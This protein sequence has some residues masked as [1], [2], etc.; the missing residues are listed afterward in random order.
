[1]FEREKI[2]VWDL[3]TNAS[4]D[5]ETALCRT[6]HA[7]SYYTG[8]Y[9]NWEYT[10]SVE[11][12]R[13][14]LEFH[15]VFVT[16]NGREFDI[17]ILQ[18]V[19]DWDELKYKR[20]IDLMWVVKK[21]HTLMKYGGYQRFS[22]RALAKEFGLDEQKSDLD[23]NKLLTIKSTW[24]N[25]DEIFKYGEQDI[26]TTKDMFQY[27]CDYFSSFKDH[28]DNFDIESWKWLTTSP[29]S[30]AYKVICHYSGIKE[31][32]LDEEE[33][34]ELGDIHFEGGFV[35]LPTK[36]E[37]HDDIY[38]C[39][40]SSAYPHAFMMM[41]LF[42]P[43]CTCC[44]KEEKYH[45]G[46]IFDEV[47][48]HY[49]NK[50][51]HPITETVKM[52][53]N[54]R[55]QYKKEKNPKQ[56]SIKIIIN[57]I[58]GASSNP[59]FKN[60]FDLKGASDCTYFCRKSIK[61]A[62]EVFSKKGYDVLY[63]DSVG[64]ESKLILKNRSGEIGSYSF[65]KLWNSLSRGR[66]IE[67]IGSKEYIYFE[68]GEFLSESMN[69]KLEIEWK[70]VKYIMRHKNKK[71]CYK[72]KQNSTN[73]LLV[74]EDHSVI[75]VENHTHKLI[76]V[77][78]ENL[79][80]VVMN[81]GNKVK[82]TRGKIYES[83]ELFGYW[84]GNGSYAG[85]YYIGIACG[86]DHEE[87]TKKV[88]EHIVEFKG[89]SFKPNNKGDIKVCSK[90]VKDYMQ[91][92]GF[93][94]TSKTKRIPSFVFEMEDDYKMSFIRG[95]FSADG[96]VLSIGSIRYTTV[97]KLLAE[98]LKLLLHSVGVSSTIIKESNKNK[99]LGKESKT[100]SHH[101]RISS[102]CTEHFKNNIGFIFNRKQ[103]RI[104]TRN[105]IVS[106]SYCPVKVDKVDYD[107]YVY[108][109]EI[110][111]NHNFFANDILVHNTDSV[112]IK[113]PYKNKQE[114]TNTCKS[115]ISDIQSSVPFPTKTFELEI[116]DEISDMWFYQ[117]DKTGEFK[118]KHYIYR[119][120]EG[121]VTLKGIPLIKRDATKLSKKIYEDFIK[122]RIQNDRKLFVSKDQIEIWA[123]ELIKQDM[124][125]VARDFNVKH[126]SKY[127][128]ETSIHARVSK[129][130]GEG[131]H[132]L[133][134]NNKYGVGKNV[135]YCTYEEFKQQGL[136]ISDC[137]MD[138]FWTEMSN[139]I[140]ED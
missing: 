49:C 132:V 96:T 113:D 10:S 78:P 64:G 95:M 47:Q 23:Y 114:V 11:K 34:D 42:G 36:S 22:M 56:F 115:I 30:Y 139:F 123:A 137:D 108:D 76:E 31:E 87:F 27:L 68:D 40:F 45:G 44:T 18:R 20:N 3:E 130:Y 70:P 67:N 128:S 55:L 65:D 117:D 9:Y 86:L 82:P 90:K 140:K 136:T 116:D 62:R 119:T 97:N 99:Y 111:E 131:L 1:M 84:I 102:F 89:L 88:L 98:D 121:K 6:F 37:I 57:T 126:I 77:K 66:E 125:L 12:I 5:S 100:Y 124:S 29:G 92:I 83:A 51:L 38:A 106:Y 80:K 63:T 72:I 93:V 94:G 4:V 46:G 101:I 109:I 24:E 8:N 112:Y 59:I 61:H 35:A 103:D 133:I 26:K 71:Q 135:K 127:K 110:E 58:F 75:N 7:Y 81:S 118:K 129:H 73:E 28:L 79:K 21:R 13:K 134:K 39:D 32:Y 17:P 16:F 53:Y 43:S 14:I 33:R 25:K 74:T 107:G 60:L 69:K 19:M 52:L 54:L 50:K 85:E 91:S 2:L 41:N 104:K 105:K 15:D 120:N 138:K 122:P 48:G